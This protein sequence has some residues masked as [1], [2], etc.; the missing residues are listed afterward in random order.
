MLSSEIAAHFRAH[1]ETIRKKLR[2]RRIRGLKIGQ[3][4]RVPSSEIKRIEKEGG[5]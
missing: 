2:Q 4:W 1:P 3:Q 5:L